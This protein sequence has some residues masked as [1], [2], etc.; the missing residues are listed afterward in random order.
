M[1]IKSYRAN[2][3]CLIN[4]TDV[5]MFWMGNRIRRN[6]QRDFSLFSIQKEWEFVLQ[7]WK[8]DHKQR[9]NGNLKFTTRPAWKTDQKKCKTQ[10]TR[11]TFIKSKKNIHRLL[12]ILNTAVSNNIMKSKKCIGQQNHIDIHIVTDCVHVFNK[13][14]IIIQN[15]E[16]KTHHDKK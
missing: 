3:W 9:F 6:V 8:I 14:F 12:L 1:E 16:E 11:R 5:K 2:G 7:R 15:G 10:E 4:A 13:L